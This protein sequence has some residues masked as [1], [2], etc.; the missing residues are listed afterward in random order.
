M[1]LIFPS[2][3]ERE[4]EREREREGEG[5][6]EREG[7]RGRGREGERER[8]SLGVQAKITG[9]PVVKLQSIP[10]ST[11]HFLRSFPHILQS[12]YSSHIRQH[13]QRSHQALLASLPATWGC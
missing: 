12:A 6:G 5:E 1:Y 13:E 4:G 3:R 10:S 7:G 8:E 2:E 9:S 11:H